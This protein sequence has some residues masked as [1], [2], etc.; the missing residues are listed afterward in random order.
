MIPKVTNNKTDGN[1]GVTSDTDRILAIIAP[2]TTG[3]YDT[4]TS[5]TQTND[6]KTLF[7]N[8]KLVKAALYLI[9]LGIPV[10]LI[11]ANPATVGDY[12]TVDDA[13]VTGTATVAEGVTV[14]DDDYDVIVKIITGGAL[15]TT[16]ITYVFSLDGGVSWSDEQSLGTSLTLTCS[17]GVSFALSSSA[18]TLVANDT[19]SVTTTGPK[20][21]TA[22]LADSF[23]ALKDY[24]GE[25]LR[26]L[27]VGCDAD[28]TMLAQG[29]AFAK[30]FW[31]DGKN[32][33]VIMNTRARGAAE[34]RATYQAAMAAIK[35]AVSTA[36]VNGCVDQCEM[37]IDGKRLR[38]PTAI[39]VAARL[40]LNDDSQD[41]AAKADG[42]LPSVFLTTAD[43]DKKYHDERKYPGLDALYFT[44]LRTWG[45]KPA[46]PGVY[47]N[48][49]RVLTSSTSDYQFFQ[50]TAI[51]NRVIE[52]TFQKLEPRLSQGVLLNENG[53]IRE[54][55]ATAIEDS[56][57]AELRSIYSDPGRVSGILFRLSRVDNVLST[58]KLSF[59]VGVQPLG[60]VK[61]FEGKTGLV[62][63]LPAA[64]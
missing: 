8:G 34:T 45:G 11:R 5:V 46:S 17:G 55:V 39:A 50:H 12:G 2:A 10:L 32:P 15:G 1:L 63:A 62:R 44:T 59:S 24:D 29:D 53:T 48:N 7:G 36:E 25:W 42:A 27:V 54:D 9:G 18:S 30:S 31:P 60:Y 6:A 49:A 22:D 40:M 43:G 3:D 16:G 33:E 37:V 28:A 51:V 20:I 26:V 56:V 19:W 61:F 64:A 4:P 41:A 14:P 23:A 21:G 47:V 38:E 52:T 58:N 57:N 13:G 35:A